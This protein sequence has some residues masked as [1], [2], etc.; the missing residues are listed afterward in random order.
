M[1]V[2][3]SLPVPYLQSRSELEQSKFRETLRAGS[4]SDQVTFYAW[5]SS[6]R[7]EVCGYPWQK[8]SQG[9][10]ILGYPWQSW[11]QSRPTLEQLLTEQAYSGTTLDRAG[12]E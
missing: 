2:I 10:P 1:L 6:S 12:S 9:S 4:E 7:V 3:L 8:S 11:V 5:Q